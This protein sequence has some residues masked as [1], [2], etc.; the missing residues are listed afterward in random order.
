MFSFHFILFLNIF[1]HLTSS[2]NSN[3]DDQSKKI[4]QTTS[5]SSPQQQTNKKSNKKI[6]KSNRKH[7]PPIEYLRVRV[8]PDV[9]R[10]VHEEECHLEQLA[11]SGEVPRGRGHTAHE[12]HHTRAGCVCVCVWMYGVDMVCVCVGVCVW[13]Y[14]VDMVCGWCEGMW[15]DI[16]NVWVWVD[17][18]LWMICVSEY[19]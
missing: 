5:L 18:C 3:K 2:L 11:E 14:G 19:L 12:P 4:T 13:M 16:M 15:M 1:I 17:E 6:K 10:C 9:L 8:R 7:I